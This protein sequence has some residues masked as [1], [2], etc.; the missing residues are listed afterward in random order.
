MLCA[1]DAELQSDTSQ[2][3]TFNPNYKIKRR[4]P[5]EIECL[6]WGTF[7]ITAYVV[8]KEGYTWI[9][10]DA[11]NSPSGRP[12]GMLQLKWNLDFDG[13]DGRGSMGRCRLKVR[14][15]R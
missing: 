11:E 5:F 3:P 1:G 2:H 7:E 8:L 4:P 12:N 6:G 13:F 14:D 9:S 10:E 15:D